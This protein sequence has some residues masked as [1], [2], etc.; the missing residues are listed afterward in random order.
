MLLS[1]A[2]ASAQAPPKTLAGFGSGY[3]IIRKYDFVAAILV[4]PL[5]LLPLAILVSG[6]SSGV[7]LTFIACALVKLEADGSGRFDEQ[8]RWRPQRYKHNHCKSDGGGNGQNDWI[9]QA[10]VQAG[11]SILW[12]VQRRLIPHQ[13]PR[14]RF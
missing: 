12:Q 11:L 1:A 7:T 9:R 5:V 13:S 4:L 14:G 10:K 6:F 8:V 3:S 2:E